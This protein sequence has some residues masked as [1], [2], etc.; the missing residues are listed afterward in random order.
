MWGLYVGGGNDDPLRRSDFLREYQHQLLAEPLSDLWAT[1]M[2]GE[3]E[4]YMNPK[5]KKLRAE[6]SKK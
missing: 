2:K 6:R 5:I 4:N 1:S 3:L